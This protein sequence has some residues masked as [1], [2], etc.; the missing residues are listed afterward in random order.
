MNQRTV[1]SFSSHM[2]KLPRYVVVGL[3]S[4]VVDEFAD[5]VGKTQVPQ[6]A[7]GMDG[8]EA[9]KQDERTKKEQEKAEDG[10]VPPLPPV[11]QRLSTCPNRGG[12]RLDL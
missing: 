10:S 8:R 12:L 1:C 2:E 11:L 4:C 9:K 7:K 3:P 5:H 6:L